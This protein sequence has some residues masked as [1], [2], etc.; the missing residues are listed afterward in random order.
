MPGQGRMAVPVPGEERSRTL[1]AGR[2]ASLERAS[3]LSGTASMPGASAV[4]G[5]SGIP[6]VPGSQGV[7]SAGAKAIAANKAASS[8]RAG[9]N[10]PGRG[11]VYDRDSHKATAEMAA[12]QAG[13]MRT[14]AAA[15][16]R[17][18]I[19]HNAGTGS[20]PGINGKPK[21]NIPEIMDSVEP[22]NG[23]ATARGSVQEYIE[24]QRHMQGAVAYLRSRN[25]KSGSEDV[26]RLY[27]GKGPKEE[28]GEG[29]KAEDSL[30]FRNR[31]D[32]KVSTGKGIPGA[33]K[34]KGTLASSS[35][36]AKKA[37]GAIRKFMALHR[38]GP[39][40]PKPVQDSE[41]TTAATQGASAHI[42]VA[43]QAVAKRVAA[44]ALASSIA[45]GAI[46]GGAGLTQ[47]NS[48]D[49][50]DDI[51]TPIQAHVTVDGTE[52]GK[53]LT[54]DLLEKLYQRMQAY[55]ILTNSSSSNVWSGGYTPQ[56]G[57]AAQ[58][59]AQYAES[60]VGKIPY[61]SS[62][63]G[64]D[65]NNERSKPLAVGRGSD[66]SWFVY[67]VLKDCGVLSEDQKFI[68]SYQWGSNPEC[69]PGGVHV[70][71]D[72]SQA[73]PGDILCYA[74][75]Y[76]R[77]S[78]NSHVGIYVGNGYWVECSG[79]SG[80]VVKKKP[81]S[82][83]LIQIVRFPGAA[84][85][86]TTA[87]SATSTTSTSENQHGFSPQTEAIVQA[88]M[89]DFTY[90]TFDAFMASQG[91]AE[92]YVRSL[93]GVFT[94]WCG[95]QGNVQTAA[96]F[97]E[98]AEYV[99][100]IMTIWGPDYN[101]GGGLHKFNGLWGKGDQNGR[102]YAGMSVTHNWRCSPLETVYFHD[103]DH[104]MTDC[105]C[106]CAYIMNKA[107]LLPD[108]IYA[109]TTFKSTAWRKVD[110]SKGGTVITRK[111]DLQVGDMLQM[112]K[113]SSESGWKHVCVVGEI[114]AD[115]TIITY[116]TGNRYVNTSNYKKKFVVKSDG[117]IGGDYNGYKSWF[118]MR[119]R[120]LDQTGAG[121]LSY[122]SG[123]AVEDLG[124]IKINSVK[125]DGREKNRS[126]FSFDTLGNYSHNGKDTLSVRKEFRF[127]D[128]NGND[129]SKTVLAN[130][131][132]TDVEKGKKETKK[133]IEAAEKHL[134]A[135]FAT[136][137]S[138]W[139]GGVDATHFVQKVL[140]EAGANPGGVKT[141][142][143]WAKAGRGVESLDK[144]QKGDVI[145]YNKHVAI[146]D[147]DGKIYECSAKTNG[148]AHKR[149][150]TDPGT[151][152]HIR[153]FVE[154]ET[155]ETTSGSQSQS[156]DTYAGSQAGSST[157]GADSTGSGSGITINIPSGLGSV[158]TY[159]GWQCITAPSSNQYKLREEAGMK[160]DSEGFGR[161]NGRYVIA[162]T[163]TYGQVGDCVDFYKK[164]GQ[165][166]HGVIGD[167]KSQRDAGC[168]KWGHHN[169]R[170]VIEFIVNK[171]TWYSGGRG[172]HINPGNPGCHP[173][174][175]SET[176]KAVNLG[177]WKGNGTVSG[178]DQ[179]SLTSNGMSPQEPLYLAKLILSMS[180]TGAYSLGNPEDMDDYDK[181]GF[182]IL[183][184]AI[185]DAIGADVEY[186]SM[187]DSY[188]CT[189]TI[190][191]CCDPAKLEENDTNFKSWQYK[192]TSGDP[193]VMS[194]MGLR[195]DVFNEVMNV[196]TFALLAGN[197]APFTGNEEIVYEYF[198]SKGLNP[199][200]IAAI[201]ANIKAESGFNPAAVNEN[202]GA[203]GLF[204]WLGGRLDNLK[205]RA[206]ARGKDWT[207]MQTQLDYAWEEMKGNG[208]NGNNAQKNA[209]FTS[210]DPRQAAII[211]ATYWERMGSSQEA[212]RRGEIA[213]EYYATIINAMNRA[214][215]P[216]GIGNLEYVQ[217]ALNIAADNSHGYDQGPNGSDGPGI[218]RDGKPD[219]DCSSLVY[220]ALKSSGFD[221]GNSAFSTYTMV[222]ILLKA[223]FEQHE[224]RSLSELQTGDILYV[225]NSRIQHTEIYYQ[226][227][228]SVGA[229][230][231]YDGKPGDSSGNEVSVDGAGTSWSHYFRC[232]TL[233]SGTGS[234][235]D[236]IA[237]LNKWSKSSS[238]G[239]KEVLEA[240]NKCASQWHVSKMDSG[241][242]WCSETASAAYAALG[243]ADR[244]GGMSSNGGDY[245]KRAR[246]IGAWV[247]DKNYRPNIGDI[248][249]THDSGGD[250]SVNRHT[251]VV[252][253]CSGNKIYTIAGGGSG[254]HKSS[255]TVGAGKISGFVV[256][257][258]TNADG[259]SSGSAAEGRAVTGDPGIAPS[260]TDWGVY[261]GD[262][263]G[264]GDVSRVSNKSNIVI[265]GLD[266]S[267]STISKI[268]A[269]GTKVY[270]YLDVGS[271]ENYRPYYS[272]FKKYALGNYD[273]WPDEKWMDVS[274]KDWQD[275]VVDT[276]VETI[277]KKG[278]DGLWLDNTD[279]Y[280]EYHREGI[281]QGLLNIL[282]RIKAK[283]IPVF[284]NGGNEFVTRLIKEN[285]AYLVDGVMQEE[286]YTEIKDYDHDKFA[287]QNSS[288]RRHHEA[289]LERVKKAG[290]IPAVLEY[291][292]DPKLK[293][294]IIK[295]CKKKE[296]G[297]RYYISSTVN[298]HIK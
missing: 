146:Y 182:D 226:D 103:K 41:G 184:Y 8:I 144:A 216:G 153:R 217:W 74:Y 189:A 245:E 33:S 196:D 280:E 270:S 94:K 26:V 269:Q 96:E 164:N 25:K 169:G 102:F 93:G 128:R 219:Y 174:W 92:N 264:S 76:P 222:P 293:E 218:S 213:M 61:K 52:A 100:G 40:A 155:I 65:P 223:G 122:G 4:S 260:D 191:V 109:G 244:I 294:E 95:V 205:R 66:C 242:A 27:S 42:K 121:S 55:G 120:A 295:E 287:K 298:L 200:Q 232:T 21:G 210:T 106:G 285:K 111:E 291:T 99:M 258:W 230:T 261:I 240:Y 70:G 254:I 259:Y 1:S 58:N 204:Q 220:Y 136:G 178:T 64:N 125:V 168:T 211:F 251:A 231:D 208:W 282:T 91:G 107:G 198:R 43:L 47:K 248:I 143:G 28:S 185:C 14:A 288:T 152:L 97:Q 53:S 115:G 263:P 37:G 171:D 238:K 31:A 69:Y 32:E 12:Q 29:K 186:T 246:K 190:N 2:K 289:Y 5:M 145:V 266:T 150:V 268:R 177:N 257:R 183:D 67:H 44:G 108:N 60:W 173:E 132:S 243:L 142:S 154:S 46:F 241:D 281:Y 172:S 24:Q 252:I 194:Y 271:I 159:M 23:T 227:G 148:A 247:S 292:D 170:N 56:A 6:E 50:T 62:V 34:S 277:R 79:H 59:V 113:T 45:A 130:G 38:I 140:S 147:G 123:A 265:D 119:M 212:E 188:W 236:V 149:K 151:I 82:H 253:S 176:V 262:T 279:V 195:E 160:F 105:G 17:K 167:I 36:E 239:H 237:L 180:A 297:Y 166:I 98:V 141:I 234:G 135:P 83:H 214:A 273:N 18:G 30:R 54:Q 267:A 276:L 192:H 116:D 13:N 175:A 138:S 80:G 72:L 256:P 118:G 85:A 139:S 87:T 137:G 249:I 133:I 286:V 229:H 272:K 77:K 275:Y 162:C 163:T 20:V 161:I 290:I 224:F 84:S 158:H 48:S 88:H 284:I 233:S 203:S 78:S 283:G 187:G 199:A 201:M 71:T 278:C 51:W 57:A 126:K 129:I 3:G 179:Y 35:E 124:N 228:K 101:G 274:N 73:Q 127:V 104:I 9:A 250:K 206:A 11:I 39:F 16:N 207:D 7:I 156:A 89:N 63:T 202:S 235:A 209:F 197:A 117:T 225:H 165:V 10:Q 15:G 131:S 215:N 86:T 157:T 255:V 81:S 114:Y 75:S 193:I 90:E 181:Y 296:K 68:H 49:R 19:A 221:V 134:G 22:V 112:S 110:T